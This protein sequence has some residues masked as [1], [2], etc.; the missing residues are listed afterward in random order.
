MSIVGV[1]TTT[2]SQETEPVTVNTLGG[3]APDPDWTFTDAEGHEHRAYPGDSDKPTWPTLKWVVD[4]T[5][6]C[7][8]CRDEHE[9]GHYACAICGEAI[10]PGMVRKGPETLTRPGRTTFRINGVP[11]T[12]EVWKQAIAIQRQAADAADKEIQS[13]VESMIA[14][15]RRR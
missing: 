7:E 1:M 13:L 2:F 5:Y 15:R 8:D 12:E 6:W 10:E 14:G 11:V 9:E 4:R 3:P